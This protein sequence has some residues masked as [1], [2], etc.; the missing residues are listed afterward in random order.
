MSNHFQIKIPFNDGFFEEERIMSYCSFHK[1]FPFYIYHFDHLL[2][3]I[4]I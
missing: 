3:E 1:L 2:F 4:E